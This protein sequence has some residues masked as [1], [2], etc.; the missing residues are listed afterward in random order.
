MAT[1]IL[2]IDLA[3]P[4]NNIAGLEPYSR[5][6][7]L[8][9]WRKNPIGRLWMPIHSGMIS[10]HDLW[11]AASREFRHVLIPY[12][13]AEMVPI[14][15]NGKSTSQPGRL[16]CSVVICTRNR[17]ED[18]HRALEALRPAMAAGVEVIVV[19][20]AP[21]DD[22]SQQ[23][24]KKYPVRYLQQP[25]SGVNWAR[26][27]GAQAARGEI[28]AYT[29][30]DAKVDAGWLDA[31]LEP[32]SD[33]DVAAV[34]GLVVPYEMETESQELFERYQSFVRGFARK[35][36]TVATIPAAAAA[37][38]GA[39]A[40]MALRRNLI[41]ELRLFDQELDG[42]TVTLTGGDTY[43]LYQ[44]L[45]LGYRIVYQPKAL[46][47]HR[48]RITPERLRR[49]IYGYSVGTYALLLHC[50][51]KHRDLGAALVGWDWFLHHHIK[52][53]WRGLRKK[54]DA[55][56]LWMT[57]AEIKGCFVGPFAY[58][59]SR[60]PLRKQNAPARYCETTTGA[61]A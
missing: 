27:L 31:I 33:S 11:L 1:K 41:N 53:L 5:A 15:T 60:L 58:V 40:N 56:P 18:L 51:L 29:D 50:F 16:T 59:L 39:G 20:N 36:F 17:T 26:S 57:I 30:D 35:D 47:W 10:A 61:S 12:V 45:R 8:V 24:A 42:G 6:H 14:S 3:E 22:Q 4:L 46:A 34:T 52:Q 49:V 32:F 43:A 21:D 23:L 54:P 2:D 13:A 19:D 44:V 48:H 37:R 7:V 28:V 38:A 9:R 55:Q 25:R